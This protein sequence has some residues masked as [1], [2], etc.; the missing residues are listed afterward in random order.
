MNFDFNSEKFING[1]ML[2]KDNGE[3]FKM[4]FDYSAS[5]LEFA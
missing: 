1:R 5:T 3:Y 2:I 4:G